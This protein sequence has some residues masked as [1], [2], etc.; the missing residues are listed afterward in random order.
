MVDRIVADGGSA[1]FL[2]LDL[3]SLESARR[4]AEDFSRTGRTLD[5]LVN[6]AGVGGGRGLT[7]DG[8]EI[9][10]GVNHLGHFMLTHHLRET[11]RP[12]T[13]IVVVSSEA[14]RRASGIDFDAVRRK[15]RSFAGLAD[16]GASKLANILFARELARRRPEWHTYSLHP[17]LVNTNILPR[18]AKLF[19]RNL[20]TPEEGA[21]TSVWCATSDDVADESGLY[22]SR[23]RLREPSDV[24]LDDELAAELWQRSAEWC[25]L[26][27]G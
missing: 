2:H 21:E 6:N 16:Y 19:L 26:A 4:A 14:H 11:L 13:R 12:G 10:F 1:E 20:L 24:A 9:H 25:G 5:V 22:Y 17:G 7:E 3:A 27:L 18:F 8:F 15:P 23:K